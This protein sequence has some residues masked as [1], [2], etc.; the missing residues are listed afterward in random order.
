MTTTTTE[1]SIS[2]LDTGT[3]W[4]IVN[5]GGLAAI[6]AD[7]CYAGPDR[8]QALDRLV[9][10]IARDI[11]VLPGKRFRPRPTDAYVA[12][13]CVA[14][15]GEHVMLGPALLDQEQELLVEARA[16]IEQQKA[17][18]QT[19]VDTEETGEQDTSRD[20]T[21]QDLLSSAAKRIETYGHHK[22]TFLDHEAANPYEA[23]CCM[24]GAIRLSYGVPL[25][26][27]YRVHEEQPEL[28]RQAEELLAEVAERNLGG[29]MPSLP[30]DAIADVNDAESFTADQAIELLQDAAELA[31]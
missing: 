5:P 3:P 28:V 25:E 17:A 9:M 24:A 13:A 26:D 15:I 4:Y 7:P 8:A 18:R 11:E 16:V 31:R 12:V 19:A 21:V 10:L 23:P 2:D 14:R 20:L 29:P 30:I 1:I 6:Q 22:E 27:I